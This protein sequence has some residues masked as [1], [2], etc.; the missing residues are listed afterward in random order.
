MLKYADWTNMM[1]YDLHGVWDKLNPIGDIIQGHTNLT[2]I[3]QSMDLLWRNNIPPEQVVLGIGFYGRSFQLK[4]K[5]CSS[6]GCQFAGAAKAG[7]CTDNAGT[8][9]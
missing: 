3:K 6:P 4:S 7:D 5:S 2:E 1:T 8:L 9:A